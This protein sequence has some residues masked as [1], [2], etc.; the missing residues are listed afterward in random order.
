[1]HY[2]IN[3]ILPFLLLLLAEVLYFKIALHFKI[4]DKPNARSSHQVP[5]IRGGG[6][7]F[8]L[9]VLLFYFWHGYRL[10][11][12]LVALLISGIISFVDDVRT[13]P[14]WVKFAAHAV[15]VILIFRECEILTILHPLYLLVIG[16]L[17]IGI[18]N[19]YNFMDGINGITGLY[20]L[21]VIIPL[22]ITEQDETTRSLQLF[23]IMA[24]IVF[25][26]FNTRV[27]AV[28]FA[29]DVGS[30]GMS[31]LIVYLLI[32]RIV[33]T[34]DFTYIGMLLIYGIDSCYTILHRVIQRENIFKPH[35]KHLY[36]FL[37]NEKKM[38]QLLVS[39]IFA[40]LQFI[41]SLFIVFHYVDLTALVVIFIAL[42]LVYWFIKTPYLKLNRA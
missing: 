4:I 19:A 38:S 28:C 3:Y 15:S 9:G 36:Q 37:S 18:I 23:S 40:S 5:T 8:I 22:F 13:L 1:M 20:S 42:T 30:I 2:F 33:Q 27:K 11:Y 24:L 10:P 35:R 34:S 29:G 39:F 6:I 32:Q 26:Y 7:I 12:L 17:A 16:V 21:A 25:N 41:I 31:I 14:N